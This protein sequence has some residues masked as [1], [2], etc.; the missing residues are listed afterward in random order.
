MVEIKYDRNLFFP[1]QQFES[2]TEALTFLSG[3]L[4]TQGYA[5]DGYTEAILKREQVYPTGLPSAEPRVA[6]PHADSKFINQTAIAVATLTEPVTFSD[7]ED[8]KKNL[9]VSIIIMLAIK[10]PHGQVEMLQSVVGIIQNNVLMK[11][12]LSATDRD[13]LFKLVTSNL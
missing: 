10:E 1:S 4:I 11:Q 3:Q 8:T 5:K 7:M 12:I 13:T 9:D 2:A 6:I